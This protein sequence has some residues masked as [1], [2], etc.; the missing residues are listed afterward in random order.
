M[1]EFHYRGLVFEDFVEAEEGFWSYICNFHSTRVS[2][3]VLDPAGDCDCLCG[4]KGCENTS[5]FYIDF[6]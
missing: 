3:S 1:N 5:K 2:E 6:D 4:V